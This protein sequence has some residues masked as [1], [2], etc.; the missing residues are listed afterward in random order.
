MTTSTNHWCPIYQH[1]YKAN[2]DDVVFKSSNTA[3]LGVVI[4]DCQGD[5]LGAMSVRVPLPHSV[6]EV[7]AF[8]CRHAV[9]FAIDL[10]LHEV[11][12]EVDSAIIN[13][14]INSSLSSPALYGHIVDDIL[15]LT[16]QLRSHKFSQV[17]R[18]CNKVAD[19]FAKKA[20]DGLD[21]KIWVDDVPGDI[22]PLALFDVS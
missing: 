14:A 16:L 22:I 9:F 19:A 17:S 20:R 6:L 5:I 3:G 11:I 4:R 2:Y 12:F 1:C 21:F 15:H 8:A 13:Q 7:E 18:C 10:G